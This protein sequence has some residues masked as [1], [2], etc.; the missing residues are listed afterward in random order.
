MKKEN[1]FNIKF[2]SSINMN[3]EVNYVNKSLGGLSAT[4]ITIHDGKLQLLT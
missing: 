4:V 3:L 2:N 1:K